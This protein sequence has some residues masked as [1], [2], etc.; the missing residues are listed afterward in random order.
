[1]KRILITGGAGYIGSH[2]VVEL[3]RAG[4][5]VTIVDNFCTSKP[6]IIDNIKKITQKNFDLIKG[7]VRDENLLHKVFAKHPYYA[8][9]H[10]A[11]YKAVGESVSAPLNYYDNN[12][13]STI[14]LL[15]AMKHHNCKRLVFSSSATVYGEPAK[16]PLTEKSP[17][18]PVNP[19][20]RTKL[21]IEEMLKDLYASDNEWNIASLRYFNPVA[22]HESGLLEEDPLGIPNNLFPILLKVARGHMKELS[23]FGND[24]PTPDGTAKRDYIHVVDLAKGH[25]AALE[26]IENMGFAVFNLGTGVSFSV[27]EVVE[28]FEKALGRALPK[29]V[30]DR[31]AGDVVEYLACVKKAKEELNFEAKRDLQDMC[32]NAV[33]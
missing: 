16:L 24:Y 5:E 4:Y 17:L 9:V 25:L 28:E 12:L 8:V 21:M 22:S 11:G 32:K 1:M 18:N 7:D 19:Y 27:L 2:I 10:L 20:G 14:S 15:K 26:K 13:I 30:V 31:R 3:L 23:I 29:R 6:S 33:R